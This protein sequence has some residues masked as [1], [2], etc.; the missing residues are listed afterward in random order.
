MIADRGRLVVI[1]LQ[2]RH[3]DSMQKALS[4]VGVC[5]CMLHS[6]GW[7]ALASISALVWSWHHTHA[8]HGMVAQVQAQPGV[9]HVLLHTPDGRL[10]PSYP[11]P[12]PPTP[13][14][15]QRPLASAH[16]AGVPGQQLMMVIPHSPQVK[17]VPGSTCKRRHKASICPNTGGLCKEL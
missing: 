12:H 8:E 6:A 14:A 1:F 13:Y 9:H 3:V 4:P 7:H 17:E 2:E 15:Q 16:L 5:M 11:P 10:R